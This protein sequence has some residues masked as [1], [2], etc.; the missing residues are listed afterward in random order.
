MQEAM[1]RI[2]E[3][4]K[5]YIV[6]LSDAS[7][8]RIWRADMADTL[9]WL[10]SSEID[11]VKLDDETCSHALVNRSDG[12]HVRVIKAHKKWRLVSTSNGH[13]VIEN[14]LRHLEAYVTRVLYVLVRRMRVELPKGLQAPTVLRRSVSANSLRSSPH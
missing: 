6:V 14:P 11:V 12:S 9:Q 5:S 13:S 4:S 1:M 2:A 3:H 7:A 10:P 8:W